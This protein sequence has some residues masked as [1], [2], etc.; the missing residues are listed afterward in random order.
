[1]RRP[2]FNHLE[3]VI[4]IRHPDGALLSEHIVRGESVELIDYFPNGV[5]SRHS[6]AVP[7]ETYC[8]ELSRA[9][10]DGGQVRT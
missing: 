10:A 4:R 5:I 9:I 6:R 1:M 8:D 7:L 2:R 3:F